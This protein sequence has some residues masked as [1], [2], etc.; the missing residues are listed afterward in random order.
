MKSSLVVFSCQPESTLVENNNVEV[1]RLNVQIEAL[2]NRIKDLTDENIKIRTEV[3]RLNS[4]RNSDQTKLNELESIEKELSEASVKISELETNNLTKDSQIEK[5]GI[6]LNHLNEANN[7]LVSELESIEKE[8]SDASDKISELENNNSAKDSEIEGLEKAL[9]KAEDLISQLKEQ[10]SNVD[11]KSEVSDDKGELVVNDLGTVRFF[12]VC[13]KENIGQ[14]FTI[15]GVDYVL[16]DNDLLREKVNNKEDLTKVCTTCVTDM[17]RLIGDRVFNQDIGNWDVS[18]VTDMGFMFESAEA[19]NQDIGNWDVS[20]VTDMSYMFNG[21]R[22]FNQ[23]IGN[24]DVSNVTNMLGMFA[25]TRAF[26]KDIGNWDVSNVINMG[27]MFSNATAFNQDIGNWDVSNVTNMLG[28][29]AGTRA[30]NKDIGNWDV[31]NVTDMRSMF[32]NAEAFNQDI[33]NWD[34][35]NV[36]TMNAM[37]VATRAFNQDIGNWDVSNVTDMEDMFF[38]AQAFNQDI[39]NWLKTIIPNDKTFHIRNLNRTFKLGETIDLGI[40]FT[41]AESF[42]PKPDKVILS[43]SDIFFQESDGELSSIK[44]GEDITIN[45]EVYSKGRVFNIEFQIRVYNTSVCETRKQ[46]PDGWWLAEGYGVA[47]YYVDDQLKYQS[48]IETVEQR[49][50]KQKY[51]RTENNEV[52][53]IGYPFYVSRNYVEPERGNNSDYDIVSQ[54]LIVKNADD[55]VWYDSDYPY[56]N[57]DY[58]YKFQRF[59][60]EI[61]EESFSA[62]DIFSILPRNEKILDICISALSDNQAE[63]TIDKDIGIAIVRFQ[64]GVFAELREVTNYKL[65]FQG[66]LDYATQYTY[67]SNKGFY[68]DPVYSKIKRNDFRTYIEA[69]IEDGKRYGRDLS[70]IDVDNYTLRLWD[71]I[72]MGPTAAGQAFAACSPLIDIALLE[73]YWKGQVTLPYRSYIMWLIWHEL[74]HDILDL[75][76][77]CDNTQ[78]M[79]GN[80]ISRT[81]E[82]E[83]GATCDAEGPDFPV[84]FRYD[85]P[86]SYNNWQRAVKDMFTL[87]NQVEFKCK[88]SKGSKSIV[89]TH[90]SLIQTQ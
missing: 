54:I 12:G 10:L 51:F 30:F 3:E 55:L 47:K 19:F 16:V 24:W 78:I 36:T 89:C 77:T 28:M 49:S 21:A 9:S 57:K 37:F 61:I 32:E 70:H 26:N 39:S 62:K 43:G 71:E 14:T 59:I 88:N 6:D 73:S 7:E 85:S 50:S 75:D 33:G 53:E 13:N 74:G 66:E 4:I 5:L 38:K 44:T 56:V 63:V 82:Q 76:H 2:N 72:R 11:S 27:E 90:P 84:N 68:V 42:K 48:S 87:K 46:V 69:F 86:D 34:V 45:A 22:E 60:D 81:N 58:I 25:G 35:S 83:Y 18:N 29:F 31:S 20:N 67:T 79:T 41:I 8:L 23:D 80:L 1:M 15:N 64:S 52:V 65:V 40:E 17:N